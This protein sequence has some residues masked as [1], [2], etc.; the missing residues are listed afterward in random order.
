MCVVGDDDQS[1][2]KFRG[3]DI[4]NILSFEETFPGAK[5]VKLEQNYRSTN[6]ILE[7]ANSVIANNAH[8]KE[9]HLWS[10][11]GEGKEVSFIHYETAYGEAKSIDKI[12]TSVHMGKYQYQD[13]AI[14]YRIKA[15]SRCI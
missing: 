2:Y 4:T 13:C 9:K 12:Q 3:A 8:R 6:N 15:Q 11:N 10:E 14:L 1:I 7:A 5:V